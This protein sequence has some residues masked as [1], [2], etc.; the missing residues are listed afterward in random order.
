MAVRTY[1]DVFCDVCGNFVHGGSFTS[2]A[3]VR[4]LAAAEGWHTARYQGKV[5]D[6]CPHHTVSD[7]EGRDL[8]PIVIDSSKGRTITAFEMYREAFGEAAVAQEPPADAAR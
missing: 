3:R 1:T 7:L 8:T 2:I 6:F 4:K 5:R